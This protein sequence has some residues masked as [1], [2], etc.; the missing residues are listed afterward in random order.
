[1]KT[2]PITALDRML[3]AQ[4]GAADIA[5]EIIAEARSGLEPF[6][7]IPD[8]YRHCR[9]EYATRNLGDLSA[10]E[11]RQ[12]LGQPSGPILNPSPVHIEAIEFFRMLVNGDPLVCEHRSPLRPT[13]GAYL[14]GPPGVG[15]THI[16]AAF[17]VCV[18]Q[19][20][21]ED[22]TRLEATIRS[23]V[24]RMYEQTLHQQAIWTR[25]AEDGG[26][27]DIRSARPS[28]PDGAKDFMTRAARE[29]VSMIAV[30]PPEERFGAAVR[31]LTRKIRTYPHQPADML[32]LGF[33]DLCAGLQSE[34]ERRARL[35]AA[36]ENARV[37]FIDDIHP[38]GDPDRF[39]VIQQ[40]I[41]RRYELNR[42]GTFLTTNLTADEL[43]AG[44]A[45]LAQRLLS[46]CSE[47][48]IKFDFR[49]CIDWRVTVKSRR[50]RLIEGAIRERVGQRASTPSPPPSPTNPSA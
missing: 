48:F 1:M 28:D 49:G 39:H 21:D 33:E 6:C 14:V 34:P 10:D 23:L 25:P 13:L 27:W 26:R 50:I 3:A 19:R 38:K 9:L 40:L 42:P 24:Q 31:A 4:A 35:L 18:K 37:V 47:N 11:A 5:R 44:D 16:M 8:G 43:G 41:E 30:P 17:A 12:L 22:L 36:I 7:E 29:G 45:M 2:K 32:Y 15:K 46:R 20:L